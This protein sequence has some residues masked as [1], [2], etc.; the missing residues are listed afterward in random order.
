[1]KK[2]ALAIFLIL[3]LAL[4]LAAC[5]GGSAKLLENKYFSL[6]E[7]GNWSLS[8]EK[9][10]LFE[11]KNSEISNAK[12]TLAANQWSPEKMLELRLRPSTAEQ[13]DN[14][15]LNG[16]EYYVVVDDSFGTVT[17]YLVSVQPFTLNEMDYTVDIDIRNATL[18]QA[19]P[20]LE[21]LK[22]NK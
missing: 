14:I 15:T 20:L 7:A 5:G 3:A 19:T 16:I 11:L 8:E 2:Q 10:G 4:S 13:K 17:T 6:E 21:T 22:C 12:L 1:M 18:E 9:T